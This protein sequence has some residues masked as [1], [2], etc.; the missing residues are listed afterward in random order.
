VCRVCVFCARLFYVR[1]LRVSGVPFLTRRALLRAARD[2]PH[3]IGKSSGTTSGKKR[4]S[5]STT[6][7]GS[8]SESAFWFDVLAKLVL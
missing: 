6:C 7:S 3:R 2:R 8:T 5:D 4:L 1:K